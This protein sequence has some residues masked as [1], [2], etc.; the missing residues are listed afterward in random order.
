M[1]GFAGK[2]TGVWSDLPHR[3]A[4]TPRRSLPAATQPRVSGFALAAGP[5]AKLSPGEQ[6]FI[7]EFERAD[8]SRA[9]LAVVFEWGKSNW[10]FSRLERLPYTAKTRVEFRPAEGDPK[11]ILSDLTSPERVTQVFANGV[12]VAG[13][14][15]IRGVYSP[16]PEDALKWANQTIESITSI[17]ANLKKAASENTLKIVSP[18]TAPEKPAFFSYPNISPVVR[19]RTPVNANEPVLEKSRSAGSN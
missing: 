5:A 18:A 1:G 17:T 10:G 4:D 13:Q 15:D 3:E 12:A 2:I 16:T 11:A 6:Q 19:K 9:Y 8:A 7:V 14:F